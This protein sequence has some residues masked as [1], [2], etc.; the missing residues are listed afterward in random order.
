MLQLYTGSD[1]VYF[2]DAVVRFVRERPSRPSRHDE[3]AETFDVPRDRL[4]LLARLEGGCS[5]L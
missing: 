5:L 2:A 4:G 3:P 1:L